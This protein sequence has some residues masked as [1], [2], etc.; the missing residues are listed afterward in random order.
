MVRFP[1]GT[2]KKVER[3]EKADAQ[4]DLDELTS[5][6]ALGSV[7][8]TKNV[9][10]ATFDE[11]IDEWFA[12]GCPNVLPTKASRHARVKS[13][14]TVAIAR[15]LLGTS[16]RPVIG[17]QWVDRT[18]T[19]RLEQLFADMA[20][21]DYA[22]STIDRTG[23]TSTRRASSEC[24]TGGSRR[25]RRRARKASKA[26]KSFTVEPA[27]RCKW[28]DLTALADRV[29]GPKFT[30]IKARYFTALITPTPCDPS[31]PQR[32]QAY[33]S[34]L[35]ADARLSIHCG[36][37][38]LRRKAGIL[39]RPPSV[40]GTMGEISTFEEKGSDVNLAVWAMAD[41]YEGRA[42]CSVIVSGDSD[43]VE[44]AHL[45]RARGSHVGVI[46]PE[47]GQRVNTIPRDFTKA[48]RNTDFARCQLPN[49][50]V[51]GTGQQIHR[52]PVWA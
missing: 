41:A 20:A 37:F 45:L 50:V 22:T 52:P 19:E 3:V 48:L 27:E 1:D 38:R 23:V 33:L 17:R 30:V 31:G 6:R 10:Q 7:P 34:A 29:L 24:G 43:F 26:R 49:P 4:R 15:Q 35:G 5:L 40:A 16:V 36:N 18:T 39:T 14:Y 11:I 32:Q 42:P 9:R 21:R 13:P 28:L 25:T 46:I 2:R 51:T 47:S 44:L 12:A 8:E